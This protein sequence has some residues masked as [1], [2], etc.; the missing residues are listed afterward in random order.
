MVAD[1]VTNVD[2]KIKKKKYNSILKEEVEKVKQEREHEI[3]PSIKFLINKAI[4]DEGFDG[5]GMFP[6]LTGALD[7]VFSVL[8]DHGYILK[9]THDEAP[10][11]RNQL[12]AKNGNLNFDVGFKKPHQLSVGPVMNA[13]LNFEWLKDDELDQYQIGCQLV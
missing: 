10:V 1:E 13:K 4:R 12:L 6:N 5:Q 8:D 7:L 2:V 3:F 11:S 9:P